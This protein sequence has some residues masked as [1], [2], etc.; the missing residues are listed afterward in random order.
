MF[1]R[2]F[3]AKKQESFDSTL[4]VNSYDDRISTESAHEIR[5]SNL[6]ATKVIRSYLKEKATNQI[7]KKENLTIDF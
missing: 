4:Y 6:K 3:T 1:G 7:A 2:M 5:V